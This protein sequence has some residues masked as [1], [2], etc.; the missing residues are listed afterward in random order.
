MI[1]DRNGDARRGVSFFMTTKKSDI[2]GIFFIFFSEDA[3]VLILIDYFCRIKHNSCSMKKA[4][5]T[6][7]VFATA[8]IGQRMPFGT[9]RRTKNC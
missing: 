5:L 7:I 9:T 4:V 8:I 6:I 2:S 3:S 1:M